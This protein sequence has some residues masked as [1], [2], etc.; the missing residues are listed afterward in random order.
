[1]NDT[2]YLCL[3][4]SPRPGYIVKSVEPG[5]EVPHLLVNEVTQSRAF[6]RNW[7]CFT[8]LEAANAHQAEHPTLIV[9]PLAAA[10]VIP[11]AELH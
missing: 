7:Q 9:I 10:D 4:L 6:E 8:T 1:M 11:F 5:L 3:D 2:I